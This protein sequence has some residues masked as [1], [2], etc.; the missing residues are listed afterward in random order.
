[1]RQLPS[2]PDL[3][4]FR[5]KARE[6]QRAAAPPI[7]LNAAQLAV[8]RDYGFSSWAK[9]KTEVLRRRAAA[10]AV[11]VR[12]VA[13]ADELIRTEQVIAS[14]F[15]PRRSA[16]SHGLEVLKRGSG[17]I[18]IAASCFWLRPA[19]RF[20]GEPSPLRI[21][22]AVKLN[23]IALKPDWRGLGI[24][25]RLMEAVEAEARRLGARSIYLGGANTENRA[26]Y[27]RLGCGGRKSLMQKGL[28]LAGRVGPPHRL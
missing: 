1:M 18:V 26:F 2:R 3:E 4:Q 7:N 14:E 25:R 6:L 12:P 8:A 16:P 9:L 15:P 23:A 17:P 28:P 10:S 22:D 20:S 21:G 19:A 5:H 13:S 27:W 11:T 24:G